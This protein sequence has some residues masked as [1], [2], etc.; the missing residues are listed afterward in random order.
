M[1]EPDDTL[2]LKNNSNITGK[3]GDEQINFSYKVQKYSRGSIFGHNQDRVIMITNKAFYNLKGNEIKRRIPLE[4]IYGITIS[5]LSNQFI[6]HGKSNE[7]DYLYISLEKKKIVKALQSLY[8]AK[9][10]NDLLFCKKNEK[11]INKYAIP[12][13][14]ATKNP[15]LER[16]NKAEL[17]PIEEYIDNQ[18]TSPSG[19]NDFAN[20]DSQPKP[21][22]PPKVEQAPTPA[23]VTSHKGKGIPPP[24][25]PPPPPPKVPTVATSKPSSSKPVDLA[26]ELAAKKNNLQHVEVKDYVS[27]ALK[28][29]EEGGGAA[30]GNSMMAMIMAKRNQMKKVGGTG[31][32]TSNTSAASKPAVTRPPGRASAVPTPAMN[33]PA[34]TKPAAVP[35]AQKRGSAFPAAISANQPKPATST[36]PRPG[37]VSKPTTSAAPKNPAAFKPPTA[38]GGAKPPMSTGGGGGFAAKMAALQARMAG[39]GGGSSSTSSST[40]ASTGPS[41]PIVELCEG[42]TKRMDIGN[43]IGKLEK[44]KKKSSG[45]S[46]GLSK[47]TPAKVVEGK[48]KGIPPPPPPPPPPPKVK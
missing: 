40:P 35:N 10:G 42:N 41:K 32:P 9:E 19:G 25:P 5:T 13:K 14:V 21:P 22:A 31:A 4:N 48:G 15:Y 26:A 1:V 24:P 36:G 18:D 47:V 33:N 45:T 39:G 12:K 37:G 27:P 3:I 7:Y 17:S 8:K 38:T 29:P 16:I 23:K 20:V 30:T 43:L 34:A 6:I 46:S 11:D 2:S 28:S 44:E